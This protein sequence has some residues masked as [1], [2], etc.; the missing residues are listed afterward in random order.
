[1]NENKNSSIL[2]RAEMFTF[3]LNISVY[4]ILIGVLHDFPL[5]NE[6]SIELF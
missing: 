2:K 5:F 1:M 4:L 3:V 6:M